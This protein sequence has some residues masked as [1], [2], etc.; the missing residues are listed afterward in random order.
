MRAIAAIVA[1]LIAGFLVIILV[2]IVG[3]GAT[4]SVPAGLDPYDNGQVVALLV[5]MPA[6]AQVR[7]AGGPLRRRAGRR[8]DRQAD[9]AARLGGLDRGRA[10]RALCGAQHPL[11]AACPRW[12]RRW[13][14]P[15]RCSAG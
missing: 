9:R 12:S 15:G 14:S 8:R 5:A 13:R 6:G 2:G 10:D 4:Y 1:G 11:P 3:V 7:L